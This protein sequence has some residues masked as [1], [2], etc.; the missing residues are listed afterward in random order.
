MIEDICV[1]CRELKNTEPYEEKKLGLIILPGENYWE[2]IGI[3][4]SSF[5]YAYK[6]VRSTYS[7]LKCFFT[8]VTIFFTLLFAF[9]IRRLSGEKMIPRIQCMEWNISHVLYSRYL[10]IK[11]LYSCIPFTKIR[12]GLLQFS[13]IYENS[14]SIWTIFLCP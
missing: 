4:P 6:C 9:F 14:F 10:F 2:H 3:Y 11:Y 12:I 1:H 13:L 8:S 7:K 5:L